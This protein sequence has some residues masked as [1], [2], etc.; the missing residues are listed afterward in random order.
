M[1][2]LRK[3]ISE[4]H[5]AYLRR[6]RSQLT[7]KEARF[8]LWLIDQVGSRISGARYNSACVVSSKMM[9]IVEPYEKRSTR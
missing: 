9:E 2:R 4:A 3:P 8:V 5:A 6:V 1:S 7:K